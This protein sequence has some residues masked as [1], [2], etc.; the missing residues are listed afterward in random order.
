MTTLQEKKKLLKVKKEEVEQLE[1]ESPSTPS[2][3]KR[4]KPLLYSNASPLDQ[5][6]D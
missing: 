6:S 2:K 3:I 1:K 5:Q 4:P